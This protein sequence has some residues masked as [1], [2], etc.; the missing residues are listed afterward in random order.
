MMVRFLARLRSHY[1]TAY[2]K[3]VD[4]II[5]AVFILY[6]VCTS[7][8]I[9]ADIDNLRYVG[10]NNHTA[11][12]IMDVE[13]VREHAYVANAWVFSGLADSSGL[14][15]Y[16]ISTPAAP[17]LIYSDGPPAW[18]CQ[19]HGDTLLF[20]FCR[21]SG[22][23]LYSI[24]SGMQ[25]DFLGQYNPPGEREALEGGVLVGDTL[26][27][28]AHQN[29]IY[30]IDVTNS[31]MP[32]KVG[33][34]SLTNSAVWNIVSVDSFLVVANGRFGISIIGLSGGL[35]IASSL[36]LPGLANDINC[37]GYIAA[38]S[39][40]GHGLATVDISD[41]YHPRVCDIISTA[42]NVWGTG[43]ARH[44]VGSGSW[45]VLELF[46][47]SDPY[48]I[49]RAGWDNTKTWAMGADIRNDSIIVVADWRGIVCY[50]VGP[51]ATSDIDVSPQILDF[52]SVE[53]VQDTHVVVRNTGLT[54]L[55]I[56]SIDT[57]TGITTDPHS[58]S[59]QAGDSQLVAISASGSDSVLAKITYYTNDP[60]ESI[61]KQE[62]YKNNSLFP[63]IGS[64]APDFALLGTDNNYHTLSDY[65]GKVVV[66]EFGGAW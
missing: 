11:H 1:T 26:Y 9:L 10:H 2:Y 20:V 45:R 37:D 54:V 17:E 44:Y 5:A 25:P 6:G 22:V 40:G 56:D 7:S 28:A 24:V 41:P 49:T 35:H 46:D 33:E 32:Y 15:T 60:D 62:V 36:S 30:L 38:I 4:A 47:I 42:G 50:S 8:I 31:M 21:R 66:L 64:V 59:V 39:L 12:H 27:C 14:E 51:D 18:R 13:I 48:N 3:Q 19:S 52:G 58:F 29:G 53:D 23:R 16:D 55:Y 65:R 63:Q 43:I 61:K 57:P 34:F